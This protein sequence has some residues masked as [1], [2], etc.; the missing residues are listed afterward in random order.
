VALYFALAAIMWAVI[1]GLS[2]TAL[3][4]GVFPLL[5]TKKA[6][7]AKTVEKPVDFGRVECS[8][9]GSHLVLPAIPGQAG[10][11]PFG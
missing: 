7:D 1:A 5:S 8:V 11:T 10:S 4:F 2:I 6:K 3:V 9:C